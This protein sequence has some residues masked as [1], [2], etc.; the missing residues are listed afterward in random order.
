MP[1]DKEYVLK[2]LEK[3]GMTT[4]VIWS[5]KGMLNL[6][7]YNPGMK[8]L[9]VLVKIHEEINCLTIDP[10]GSQALFFPAGVSMS[11]LENMISFTVEPPE[12]PED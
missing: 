1:F 6:S 11:G 4:I 9:P 12:Y 7:R 8:D 10:I 3:R 2:E 5:E